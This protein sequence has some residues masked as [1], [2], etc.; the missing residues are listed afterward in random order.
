MQSQ[1]I[2]V[3]NKM[4]M[5]INYI[6]IATFFFTSVAAIFNVIFYLT[7]VLPQSGQDN[8]VRIIGIIVL[9]VY[10]FTMIVFTILAIY[11]EWKKTQ[12]H[13]EN[14]ELG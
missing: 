4:N 1:M 11:I 9:L 2:A 10:G 14:F 8:V 12:P 13:F 6:S 3:D 5:K 7:T